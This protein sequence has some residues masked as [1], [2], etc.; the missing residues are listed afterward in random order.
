MKKWKNIAL[1]AAALSLLLS[2]APIYA[3]P[4]SMPASTQVEQSSTVNLDPAI[5]EQLTKVLNKLAAG[6]KIEF[7]SVD[8]DAE[9]QPLFVNG[10]LSGPINA[11]IIQQYN[12]A[13]KR[14]E[15]TS[16]IYKSSNTNA[17]LGAAFSNKAAAFLKTFD[18]DHKFKTEAIWRV[19]SPYQDNAPRN[20]W[21]LWGNKQSLYIDL[22]KNGEITASIMYSLTSMKAELNNK[23]NRSLKSLGIGTVKPFDYA[24]RQKQADKDFVWNYRDDEANNR[25]VIGVKTGKVWEVENLYGQDW[26][27]DQDYAKSFAKPVLSK[28]QALAAVKSK[29]KSIFGIQMNGYT[30]KIN[31]NEYT[32]TKKGATTIIGKI[33]K[34]GK[35]YS[36]QALPA[37]GIRN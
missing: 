27:N 28:N 13:K 35:F 21:V 19:Y 15:S 17:I 2:A 32:F 30:V 4:Q 34:K 10:N 5:K 1:S 33:N 24:V 22:D 37:N 8:T 14:V 25:V 12:P 3:A 6:A 26:A 9:G 31:K 23:A 20:Y 7:T 36:L 29:V 18:A 11:E 16:I